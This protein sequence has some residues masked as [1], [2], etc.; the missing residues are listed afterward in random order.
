MTTLYFGD[1]E[2]IIMSKL[3]YGDGANLLSVEKIR[4]GLE[5]NWY[6]DGEEI[7]VLLSAID[8]LIDSRDLDFLEPSPVGFV[9]RSTLEE[10]FIDVARDHLREA[11]FEVYATLP[12]EQLHKNLM[13]LAS[14]S[15]CPNGP[16][17]SLCRIATDYGRTQE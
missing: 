6:V 3:Y 17:C 4:R 1:E 9:H 12:D 5:K 15:G 16:S 14:S 13:M 8:S 10:D 7:A 11:G 2:D